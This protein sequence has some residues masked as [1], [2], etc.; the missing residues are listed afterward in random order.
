MSSPYDIFPYSLLR[1]LKTLNLLRLQGRIFHEK[2]Q[3]CGK[4]RVPRQNEVLKVV[5]LGGSWGLT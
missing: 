1:S 5:L 2:V 3:S 4:I